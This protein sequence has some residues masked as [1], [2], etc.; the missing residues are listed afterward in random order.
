MAEQNRRK[1]SLDLRE[2]G[3]N[4]YT[5]TDEILAKRGGRGPKC[6][7]CGREMFPE[8]DHGRFICACQILGLGKRKFS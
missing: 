6:P 1:P 7:D 4:Y 2:P 3:M 8:D 5:A